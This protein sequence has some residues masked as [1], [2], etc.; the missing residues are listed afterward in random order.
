MEAD[1]RKIIVSSSM[2]KDSY[3]SGNTFPV[4]RPCTVYGLYNEK[5]G[6]LIFESAWCDGRNYDFLEIQSDDMQKFYDELAEAIAE[7]LF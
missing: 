7:R 1:F 4:S 5:T 6:T 3:M 2:T